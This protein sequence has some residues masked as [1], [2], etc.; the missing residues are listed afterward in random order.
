MN[1]ENLAD[2]RRTLE[3][4]NNEFRNWRRSRQRGS[5]IPQRLWQAAAG[6]SEQHSIG[7]IAV[8]L[9]LDYTTLK[10]RIMS[11]PSFQPRRVAE[12]F[13]PGRAGSGFVEVDMAAG[14]SAGEC[15]IETEDGIGRKL[16]MHLSGA[17][18]AEVIEIAKAF[19]ESG[20]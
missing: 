11:L 17:G 3:E 2:G 8:T 16:K 5:K 4:V 18:F 1:R 7:K 13:M 9:A 6:L 15:T 20:R 10:Q 19:W 14:G 12:E